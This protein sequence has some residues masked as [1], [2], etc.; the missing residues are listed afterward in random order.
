[1]LTNN[2]STIKQIKKYGYKNTLTL[3]TPIVKICD[4]G[5]TQK[6][7]TLGNHGMVS[8]ICYRAP[9]VIL[10]ILIFKIIV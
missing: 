5:N 4:F 2:L 8:A 10:G 9:E 7:V 3:Q 1:M 6:Q